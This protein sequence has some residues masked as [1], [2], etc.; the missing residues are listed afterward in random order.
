ML[1]KPY[2]DCRRAGQGQ[3]SGAVLNRFRLD[4]RVAEGEAAAG[5]VKAQFLSGLAPK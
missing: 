3:A 1:S 4:R 2:G 5:G